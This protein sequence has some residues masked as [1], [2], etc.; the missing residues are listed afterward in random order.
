MNQSRP[1]S[2]CEQRRRT[3]A[4]A[5]AEWPKRPTSPFNPDVLVSSQHP[6]R[7][8]DMTVQ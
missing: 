6:I 8:I 2:S 1:K 3:A 7:G 4:A 5:M